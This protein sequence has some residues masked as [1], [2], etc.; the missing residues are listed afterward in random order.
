MEF[1]TNFILTSQ[2]LQYKA[3]CIVPFHSIP[4][5]RERMEVPGG[6]IFFLLRKT[7]A[8]LVE[9]KV[10]FDLLIQQTEKSI[11]NISLTCLPK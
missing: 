9:Q 1:E 3:L 5:G 6:E 10:W 7:F 11:I 4:G 8:F 2:K